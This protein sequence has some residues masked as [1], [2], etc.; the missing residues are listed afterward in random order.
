M[1][2]RF[3]FCHFF[4]FDFS[5][6]FC[7]TSHF[8]KYSCCVTNCWENSKEM[9][10]CHWPDSLRHSHNCNTSI[11]QTFVVFYSRRLVQTLSP[12]PALFHFLLIE[13]AVDVSKLVLEGFN[14]ERNPLHI[15]EKFD[16]ARILNCIFLTDFLHIYIY[17]YFPIQR[18]APR[19]L[20]M[21]H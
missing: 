18:I 14:K 1:S 21:S 13:A 11:P 16:F 4:L 2:R 6:F 9:F 7:F 19:R 8:T 5:F 15:Y 3:L 12:Q 17:I 20:N 10:A